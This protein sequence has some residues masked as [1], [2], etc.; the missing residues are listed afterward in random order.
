MPPT[1]GSDDRL[2]FE[3]A[4]VVGKDFSGRRLDYLGVTGSRFE[5][6]RFERMRV[7]EAALGLRVEQSEYID[8]SFDRSRMTLHSGG[9]PPLVPCSLPDVTLRPSRWYHLRLV[10]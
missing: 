7:R 3:H 6:C 10:A 8:C 4:E 9:D 5:R 2:T 1:T